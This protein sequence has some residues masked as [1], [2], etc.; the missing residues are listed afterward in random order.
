MNTTYILAMNFNTDAG[1][2]WGLRLPGADPAV[3]DT[4][5]RDAMLAVIEAD[6]IAGKNGSPTSIRSA[7]LIRTESTIIDVA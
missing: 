2:I 4:D 1:K 5:V 3:A 6:V 7:R